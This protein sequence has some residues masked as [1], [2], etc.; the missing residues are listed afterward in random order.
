MHCGFLFV[1]GLSAQHFQHHFPLSFVSTKKQK[2]MFSIVRLGSQLPRRVLQQQSLHHIRQFSL[3]SR[4]FSTSPSS[5]SSS[6]PPP[7]PPQNEAQKRAAAEQ[8]E[9]DELRKEFERIWLEAQR[10]KDKPTSEQ[11]ATKEQNNNNNNNNNSNNG[12]KVDKKEELDSMEKRVK[13]AQQWTEQFRVEVEK[14]LKEHSK[15]T[16]ASNNKESKDNNNNNNS[17]NNNNNNNNNKKKAAA[18]GEDDDGGGWWS[19]KPL[20][21]KVG[22]TMLGAQVIYWLYLDSTAHTRAITPHEFIA[23]YVGNRQVRSLHVILDRNIAVAQLNQPGPNGAHTVEVKVGLGDVETFERQLREAESAAN[24]PMS[25]RIAVQYFHASPLAEIVSRLLPTVLLCGAVVLLVRSRAAGRMAGGGGNPLFG[26][27]NAKMYNKD[28]NVKVRFADVAG[29]P[30]AKQEIL[31]FVDFLRE[32]ARFQKLGAKIPR[33]ALLVGPPGNGKTLLAKAA[34]GEAG[35]PFFVTS[36]AEF[37]EMFVGVGP[38]RVRDLFKEARKHAPAIVFIDEIDA[39]GRARSNSSRGGAHD[40]RESTLNALLVEMDGFSSTDNIVVLGGTNRVDVLDRALLRPGR[41]DRQ[42]TIDNPDV[43]ARAEIFRVHLRPLKLDAT[44]DQVALCDRLAKLTPGF[45]GADVANVCNEAALVAAR[46]DAV[47]VRGEHFDR[48]IERVIGGIEKKNRVLSLGE[49]R[50]IA[51]HEAG[52]AV[53]AWMLQYCDPVLKLSIVPRGTKPTG[54]AQYD[55]TDKFLLT[56]EQLLDRVCQRL[57]GPR[58]RAGAPQC[59]DDGRRG[60]PA[61]CHTARV[62]SNRCLWHVGEC[63]QRLV[64]GRRRALAVQRRDGADDRH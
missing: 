20:W 45:S 9:R 36:G 24:V 10:P 48:A 63:R 40:E 23:T 44:V 49:R 16:N 22:F 53:V 25:Q 18:D 19:S 46:D 38:S 56:R 1:D 59:G 47:A 33:G 64:P 52:H 39:I 61:L 58:R 55:G 42:I 37:L 29:V 2:T 51:Y 13:E 26:K 28:L 7:Q 12:N 54:F 32:P 35:V 57:A 30:E 60:R 41:F 5:S 3:M 21:F 34:A 4:C 6:P 62:H 43:K 50:A 8:K 31:E 15:T 27:S 11:A 17:N 14:M